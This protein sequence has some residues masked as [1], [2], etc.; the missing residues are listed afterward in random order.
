MASLK[1]IIGEAMRRG[2]VAQNA[3]LP[4]KVDMKTREQ[5]KLEVGRDVPSKE[6]ILLLLDR[7]QGR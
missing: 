7:A 3:A 1:S 6:E 5:R 2:L 4:A